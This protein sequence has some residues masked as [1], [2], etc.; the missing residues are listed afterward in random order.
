MGS[1]KY[2][3]VLGEES[4]LVERKNCVCERR[5][6]GGKDSLLVGSKS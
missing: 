6:T 5:N 2:G 4:L 1:E 3:F